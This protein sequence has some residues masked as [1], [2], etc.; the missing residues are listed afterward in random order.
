METMKKF[1]TL[2]LLGG[3][4]G[5]V[6]VTFVAPSISRMLISAP[7]SFGVN[8]EPAAD[9]SVGMLIRSQIIGF[10]VG[11]LGGAFLTISSALKARKNKASASFATNS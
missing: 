4:L 8:C 2:A 6:V 5:I 11:G 9:W 10:L 1:L 3:L 7:V